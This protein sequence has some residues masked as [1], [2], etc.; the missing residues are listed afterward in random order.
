MFKEIK[1]VQNTDEWFNL[2]TGKITGS[3]FDTIMPTARQKDNAW[4]KGQL[5]YLRKVAA[6]IL[7]G[8]REDLAYQSR[9]MIWGQ[10]H[11]PEAKKRYSFHTMQEVRDCGFY[12]DD[13]FLGSSPDGMIN[14]NERTIETK[15][16]ESKQ[17]LYYHLNPVDLYKEYKWQCIGEVR[18][19]ECTSKAGVIASFDPRMPDDRQLVIYEFEPTAE[20]FELLD[21]RLKL[22]V[23]L[24][25]EWIGD[26][27]IDIEL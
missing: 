4:S 1:V 25:T 10:T 13:L 17:H 16:P 12:T 5:T 6:E 27:P 23:E 2:R 19:S 7:T 22:A 24:I 21:H 11:E 8:E 15:C 18:L 3:H 20:E 26:K 14:E 9:S